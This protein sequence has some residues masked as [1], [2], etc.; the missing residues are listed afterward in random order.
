VEGAA[1]KALVEFL[2]DLFQVRNQDIRIESGA[3]SRQKRISVRGARG[4]PD[5]L[6][7]AGS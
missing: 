7:S 5:S 1:N 2:A 6:L 3:A 4:A